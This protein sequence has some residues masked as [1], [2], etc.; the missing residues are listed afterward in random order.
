MQE[1]VCSSGTFPSMGARRRSGEGGL[2][3][4]P[5]DGMWVG[6]RDL[7]EPGQPR[8]QKR[9]YSMTFCGVLVKFSQLPAP[10]PRDSTLTRAEHLAQ[11]RAIGTHLA[12]EWWAKVRAQE[13]RCYYCGETEYRSTTVRGR[14]VLEPQILTKDHMT[15]IARGGSDAIDNIVGACLRCN[16]RKGT[17]TAQ[18]FMEMLAD[19]TR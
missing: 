17:K 19:A 11:A 15:P 6:V 9:V 8:R 13:G 4:R 3:K 5:S 18:E 7:A 10:P 12:W 14:H 16:K 2:Y 1:R